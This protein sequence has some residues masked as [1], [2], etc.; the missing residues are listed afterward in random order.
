MTHSLESSRTARISL[1]IL[2]LGAAF[3]RQAALAS[4]PELARTGLVV[5]VY[6]QNSDGSPGHF[7]ADQA[8]RKT[9][10]ARSPYPV[11]IYNEYLDVSNPNN[12]R[13]LK[14]QRDY[15]QQK[16]AG[17]QIDVVI[18]G[19]SP[20]LE[21]VLAHRDVF[22]NAPVVFCAVDER[23]V[24]SLSLP[25]DVIGFPC[26]FELETTLKLARELHPDL[27]HVAVVAGKA[28]MDLW[29]ENA[30]KKI[31]Q[32]YEDRL[33]FTYLT[34]LTV[35]E[36]KRKLSALP[37]ESIIYYLH[38]FQDGTGKVSVPANVLETLAG[39]A[40]APIYSHVN[41]YVGRG[42]V[43][44]HVIRFSDEGE[45]AASLGVRILAGEKPEDIGVQ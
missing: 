33:E 38:V 8:I 5:V 41:T 14:L 16:Y 39:V 10:A 7:E 44:G 13:N 24:Q 35:D 4:N 30:A 37:P 3:C 45:N 19:L 6:P 9:F 26:R 15:L 21:F 17:R 43:G 28:A 2:L 42:I 1:A 23:E 40:N 31:F 20:A 18:A 11:E 29:W 22:S 34:G 27:K 32:P 12:E 25:P 36:L